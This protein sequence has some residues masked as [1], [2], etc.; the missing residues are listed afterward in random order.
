MV[1][2]I[3][4]RNPYYS[5]MGL[6]GDL[7][8]KII[9]FYHRVEAPLEVVSREECLGAIMTWDMGIDLHWVWNRA[10][11]MFVKF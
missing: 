4:G 3:S 11:H 9:K 2:F 7:F 10:H 5:H 8:D 1:A 6:D